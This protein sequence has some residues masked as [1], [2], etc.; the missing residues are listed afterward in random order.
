[1]SW[2]HR[3]FTWKP[4]SSLTKEKTAMKLASGF[5]IPEPLPV[6]T[7]IKGRQVH[8]L[9]RFLKAHFCFE[10]EWMRRVLISTK[11]FIFVLF[12]L[13]VT[14][15][16]AESL[17]SAIP[18]GT[19]TKRANSKR[20]NHRR[21]CLFQ[22]A[23][24]SVSFWL[25]SFPV[26]GW[27]TRSL[28]SVSGLPTRWRCVRGWLMRLLW[29]YEHDFTAI[30]PF[31]HERIGTLCRHPCWSLWLEQRIA[32]W[33]SGRSE[34]YCK[35]LSA[36]YIPTDLLLL[37]QRRSRP[38]PG[39]F[40]WSVPRAA[41]I[42]FG[43]PSVDRMSIAASGDRFTS[44]EDVGLPPSGVVAPPHR[45]RSWRPCLPGQPWVSGWRST[46]R[47]VPSPRSWTIGFSERGTAHN[48][49]LPRCLSSQ[50]CMRNWR[51]RGWPLSRPE[52]ARP[53][54]PS[55]LPSTAEWPRG[56]RAFPRWRERSWCTCASVFS[57][58]VQFPGQWTLVESS[59]HPRQSDWAEQSDARPSTGVSS[60]GSPVS[61]CTGL[62]VRMAWFPFG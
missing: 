22:D 17:S 26:C 32:G 24:S 9:I 50:R 4:R 19:S 55:S 33:R 57:P 1:M 6:H 16:S 10:A 15:R 61:P 3:G 62:D 54:P 34:G 28:S 39:W 45:T 13:G 40:R 51:S 47:P 25:R 14:V 35:S 8:P 43:A 5:C 2:R 37:T 56:T 49:A 44:S 42:S 21:S 23:V 7:G 36:G 27:W 52:A 11:P 41:S 30:S 31:L 18:L 59:K 38:V 53:P 60:P 48:R 20:A 46:D 58:P 29:A 12:L